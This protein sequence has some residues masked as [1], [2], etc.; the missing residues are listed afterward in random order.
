MGVDVDVV[1]YLKHKPD[2]ATLEAIVAG[3]EGPVADLVRKD[4]TFEKLGL[5]ADDY[6]SPEAVVSLLEA[7]PKLLQRPV[8]VRGGR[9]VIGR[10][11]DAVRAFLSS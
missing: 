8:L 7:H 3:L 11:R 6:T 9:A 10:P 1:L 5:R 4:A 2:R